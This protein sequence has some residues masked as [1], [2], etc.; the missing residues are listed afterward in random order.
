[1]PMDSLMKNKK[2]CKLVYRRIP[3]T[4]NY[5]S[6]CRFYLRKNLTLL[7]FFFF[8]FSS[9]LR[10]LQILVIKKQGKEQLQAQLLDFLYVMFL[11]Y[12]M[13]TLFYIK[14][15]SLKK[16]FCIICEAKPQGPRRKKKKF[17][18]PLVLRW[19]PLFRL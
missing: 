17:N 3:K 11:P 10:K 15:L 4:K 16:K 9:S 7:F 6:L 13:K 18:L 5:N 1:M 12:T 14:I 19:W 8:F 2:K